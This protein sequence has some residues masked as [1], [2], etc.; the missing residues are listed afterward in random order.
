MIIRQN[1]DSP[2]GYQSGVQRVM[3]NV[4]GLC[5][6]CVYGPWPLLTFPAG[7]YT[8]VVH[9]FPVCLKQSQGPRSIWCKQTPDS[10]SITSD[11]SQRL[12]ST[13]LYP[14]ILQ[15]NPEFLIFSPLIVI[16]VIENP[17]RFHA[18][19]QSCVHTQQVDW[20][21]SLVMC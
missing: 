4:S 16:F 12:Q 1:T 8:V 21:H 13:K 5:S 9:P 18:V 14:A 11:V 7:R 15:N 2:P 6:H 19:P 3:V 20:F 17:L 10:H